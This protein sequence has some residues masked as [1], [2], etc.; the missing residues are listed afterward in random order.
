M[1]LP[2]LFLSLIFL[3]GCMSMELMDPYRVSVPQPL[4]DALAYID[5]YTGTLVIVDPAGEAGE[6]AGRRLHR[7]DAGEAP[8]LAVSVPRPD[9]PG[10]LQVLV[11]DP[12]GNQIL[13]V[14]DKAGTTE[15]LSTGVSLEA[16]DVSEDGSFAIAYQP[17]NVRPTDA[18]V[19]FPNTIAVLNLASNPPIAE[20]LPLRTGGA[21]PI[22]AV[23][24]EELSIERTVHSG[25]GTTTEIQ[26]LSVALVFV[27]GGLI[28]VDLVRMIAM[29]FVSV[30]DSDRS[31]VPAEVIFT[32]NAGDAID[33]E[34]DGIERAFV[35][36]NDGELFAFT[37]ALTGPASEPL[38]VTLDNLVTPDAQVYDI[39]LYFDEEGRSLLLAAAGDELI[40]VDG[41][42]GVAKR[43]DAPVFTDSLVAYTDPGSGE[44][45]CL[46]YSATNNDFE[47]A[48]LNP[49]MLAEHRSTGMEV[50]SLGKPVQAIEIGEG[51]VRAILSYYGGLDLGI[52]DLAAGGQVVD[53]SFYSAPHARVLVD[54]GKRMLL[55]VTSGDDFE[56]YLAEVT[57]G[58]ELGQRQVELLE[59]GPYV[60]EIGDYIWVDHADPDGDVT[61]FPTDSL[62]LESVIA[63]H[64]IFYT[65]LLDEEK[66]DEDE[67]EYDDGGYY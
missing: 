25:G 44:A 29:D 58:A 19:A 65:R 47:L 63:F 51:G 26:E 32:N 13:V 7:I 53:M 16:I 33:G 60:G 10:S 67:D 24:S 34:V 59:D 12:G 45:L 50:M 64:G 62:E 15:T 23:F 27:R 48:R 39:E 20:T 18:L 9:V 3:T 56:P 54:D 42:S 5:E 4:D 28:P 57:F 21:R 41:Y 37:L 43:Y 22:A 38:V 40:L 2:A 36:T 35:R 1:R 55:V 61:F 30:T 8:S 46:G 14:R 6:N 11:I 49:L 31:V 52:L 17:E 66:P